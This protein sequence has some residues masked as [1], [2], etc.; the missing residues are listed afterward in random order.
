M[1]RMYSDGR[2]GVELGVIKEENAA[3]RVTVDVH[4]SSLNLAPWSSLKRLRH[5]FPA[6]TPVKGGLAKLSQNKI[7][8]IYAKTELPNFDKVSFYAPGG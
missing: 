8:D 7:E 1:M 2:R 6:G 4:W 5:M 3:E